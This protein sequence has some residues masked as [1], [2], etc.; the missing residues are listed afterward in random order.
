MSDKN[1][2]VKWTTTQINRKTYTSKMTMKLNQ[3]LFITVCTKLNSNVNVKLK[4]YVS[5]STK[6]EV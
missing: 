4:A 5:Y 3:H 1:L 2:S 6:L